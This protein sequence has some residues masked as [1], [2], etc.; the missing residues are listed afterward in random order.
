M[1]FDNIHRILGTYRRRL[2]LDI[3]YTC[4]AACPL[5]CVNSYTPVTERELSFMDLRMSREVVDQAVS[6]RLNY[7]LVTGG[8]PTLVPHLPDVIKY[9]SYK[10]MKTRVNTNGW[11]NDPRYWEGLKNNGLDYAAV[12]VDLSHNSPRINERSIPLETAIGTIDII[13]RSGIETLVAITTFLHLWD[14]E[15]EIYEQV[16]GR[17]RKLGETHETERPLLT[18]LVRNG[19]RHYVVMNEHLTYDGRDQ[20]TLPTSNTRCPSKVD[21][22]TTLSVRVNPCG[23]IRIPCST[24]QQLR[25]K[26]DL[27]DPADDGKLL[28]GIA[29]LSSDPDFLKFLG[30]GIE[31]GNPPPDICEFCIGEYLNKR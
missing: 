31:T 7:L 3:T 18:Q 28:E 10:G 4:N 15:R 12:G 13:V 9:A 19:K 14:E 5:C 16:R 26:P 11:K 25:I 2:I 24:E 17:F 23:E 21:L 29:R 22:E 6:S 27:F 30:D 20:V 1:E 8:E